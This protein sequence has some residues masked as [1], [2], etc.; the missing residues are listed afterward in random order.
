MPVDIQHLIDSLEELVADSRRLPIGGGVML[1]RAR[2]L[3]LIDQM[4]AAVP[5]DVRDARQVLQRRDET[6]NAARED[7]QRII[8]DAQSSAQEMLKDHALTRGAEAQSQEII[9]Q[10]QA[11]SAQIVRE[12]EER[13][14]ARLQQA[15]NAASEQ[16]NEADRYAMELLRRLESQLNAFLN[17]VRNGLQSFEESGPHRA[18]GARPRRN[19]GFDRTDGPDFLPP[20][21]PPA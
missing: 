3:D 5:A 7:A 21:L 17:S 15:E 9:R 2:L 20:G 18:N 1:D 16:M 14:Q 11:R 19:R 6:L 10:A 13:A 4:R 12:A 8:E